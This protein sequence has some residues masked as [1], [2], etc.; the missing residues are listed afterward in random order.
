MAS[1][2]KTIALLSSS[3]LAAGAAHGAILYEPVNITFTTDQKLALDL[4]QDG[5]PD[6]LMTF[7]GAAKPSI[8]SIL[9][10]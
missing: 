5:F 10:I 9:T 6:F 8:T 4:N 3:A 7:G 2:K 1:T